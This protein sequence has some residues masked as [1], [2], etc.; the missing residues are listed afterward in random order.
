MAHAPRRPV[1]ALAVGLLLIVTAIWGGTFVVVHDVVKHEQVLS[2]LAWRFWVAGLVLIAIRPSA[3]FRLS[4]TAKRHGCVL[5]L[6]LAVGYVTQTFGLKYAAPSVSGF[7]TGLFV[8]F[9]PI[10][11]GL[12]L[13][14][15]ISRGAWAAVVLATGGLAVLSLHGFSIGRGEALTVLAALSFA[16]HIVGLAAWS[17]AEDAYG[18]TIW[19]LCVTATLC[20]VTAPFFGGLEMPHG[21]SSWWAII[22]L[23]VAATS[24][25]FLVQTWAQAYL[26]PT[27]TAVILTMEP[28]FAGIFGVTIGG[29]PLTWRLLVG[30]ACIITAMYLAEL[31]PKAVPI[32]PR[33][34][35]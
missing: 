8:V 24:F 28:T 16:L 33:I 23:G 9:T 18:L 21:T 27:R 3:A 34:E 7:I 15:P 6:I 10:L 4:P 17:T 1:G 19:Q 5:G 32:S 30:G 11:S 31:G 35:A 13:K 26:S 14:R 20:T 12:I 29:D 22:F 25:A 2:F